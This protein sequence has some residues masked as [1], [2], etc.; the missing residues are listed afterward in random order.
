MA[1]CLFFVSLPRGSRQIAIS[2]AGR[3]QAHS[4]T[5]FAVSISLTHDKKSIFSSQNTFVAFSCNFYLSYPKSFLL[6]IY[7]MRYSMIKFDTFL[8]LFF[9][10]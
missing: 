8:H 10:I 4:S 6:F 1:K 7:N 5:N 3:I 2:A 9:Y